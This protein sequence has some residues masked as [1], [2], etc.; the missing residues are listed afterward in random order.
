MVDNLA[1]AAVPDRRGSKAGNLRARPLRNMLCE[2]SLCTVLGVLRPCGHN[3]VGDIR[4]GGPGEGDV[5][6]ELGRDPAAAEDPG[7]SWAFKGVGMG[8][9]TPR[10]RCMGPFLEARS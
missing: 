9:L 4:H 3:C 5:A 7:V 8:R 1:V 2:E 6:Y 10:T